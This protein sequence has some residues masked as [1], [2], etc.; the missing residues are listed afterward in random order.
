MSHPLVH[1]SVEYVDV[2]VLP[3]SPIQVFLDIK[4]YWTLG[5]K[6]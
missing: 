1:R 2:G 4:A 6:F 3:P 5:S